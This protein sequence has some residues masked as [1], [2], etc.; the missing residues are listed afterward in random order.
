MNNICFCPL[1]ESMC[2]W[3]C[4]KQDFHLYIHLAVVMHIDN[5]LDMKMFGKVLRWRISC[6]FTGRYWSLKALSNF[7][8]LLSL[9]LWSC[10]QSMFNE[11]MHYILHITET[12]TCA[13]FQ[14][15]FPVQWWSRRPLYV[16]PKGYT[17]NE[18]AALL[19][20]LPFSWIDRR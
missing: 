17:R 9:M 3:C 12:A 6:N 5:K 7:L 15:K 18:Y 11:L 4:C 1:S 14:T 10:C 19:V 20:A 8:F 2:M 13:S 16:E